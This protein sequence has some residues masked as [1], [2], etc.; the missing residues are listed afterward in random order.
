MSV[1]RGLP[2]SECAQ[3]ANALSSD[4]DAAGA[5]SRS[6]NSAL[7]VVFGR[8]LTADCRVDPER[9]ERVLSR[10]VAEVREALPGV[11]VPIATFVRHLARRVA[12]PAPGSEPVDPLVALERLHTIDLYLVCACAA[13]DPSA[14]AH[15]DAVHLAQ[16]D[17]VLAR[18]GMPT[19]VADETKQVLRCRFLVERTPG[20]GA[21][22]E[23]YG[24][25][26]PLR[27]WV[28]TAAVHAA[29]RIIRRPPRQV[30][31]DSFVMKAVAAPG[32]DLEVSYWKKRCANAFENALAETFAQ[33]SPR[34]R[35]ILRCYHL[36]SAGIDGVAGLYGVHRVTA[37]RWVKRAT[38]QLIDRTRTRLVSGAD[39]NRDEV[40]SLLRMIESPLEAIVRSVLARSPEPSD[41]A[42]VRF[43]ATASHL[44]V[45]LLR[46]PSR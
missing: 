29:S 40:S 9:L 30:E 41:D 10:I 34:E 35:D 24:G 42:R 43:G 28:A 6:S 36:E 7:G 31:A 15:F 2:A 3:E 25:Q 37:W 38:Q 45:S 1:T 21:S 22:I 14:L 17:H 46:G 44:G 23:D 12:Y 5:R 16:V 11:S 8:E 26:G 20:A 13:G 4:E 33:L 27:A 18:A 32:D 39:A 19:W